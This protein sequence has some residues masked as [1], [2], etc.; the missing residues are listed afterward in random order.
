M[1]LIIVFS[2]ITHH[3]ILL[4]ILTLVKVFSAEMTFFQLPI[5]KFREIFLRDN[6]DEATLYTLYS[7]PRKGRIAEK[8]PEF[9]QEALRTPGICPL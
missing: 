6:L 4:Q 5:S 2:Q 3:L 9:Y 1:Y 8:D 7:E